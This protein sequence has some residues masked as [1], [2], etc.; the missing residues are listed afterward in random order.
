[1]IVNLDVKEIESLINSLNKDGC[2]KYAN[3]L[4]DIFEQIEDE[5]CR[6]SIFDDVLGR[7]KD[8]SIGITEAIDLLMYK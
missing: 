2:S 7:Y 1:M 8:G 4:M 6:R 3:R 5:E